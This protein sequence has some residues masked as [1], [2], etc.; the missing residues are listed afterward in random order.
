MRAHVLVTQSI[1]IPLDELIYGKGK[2]CG[3]LVASRSGDHG[4]VSFVS[5]VACFPNAGVH[6]CALQVHG[7]GHLS[8]KQL[9]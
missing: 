4:S 8:G 5:G 7:K 6:K 3:S 1:S 2:T 9:T